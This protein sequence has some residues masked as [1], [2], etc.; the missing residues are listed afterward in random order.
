V[1]IETIDIAAGLMRP[2]NPSVMHAAKKQYTF[3]K[4]D[5]NMK[6]TAIPIKPILMSENSEHFSLFCKI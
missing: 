5:M 6:A 1:R 2:P 3:S 4:K